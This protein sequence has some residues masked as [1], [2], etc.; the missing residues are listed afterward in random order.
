MIKN[1]TLELAESLMLKNADDLKKLTMQDLEKYWVDLVGT[2]A[3]KWS[4]KQ[5]AADRIL[6]EATNTFMSAGPG[7][8]P[9][10]FGTLTQVLPPAVIPMKVSKGTVSKT[11]GRP[12]ANKKV[13]TF[14]MEFAGDATDS[15]KRLPKQAK[16][17]LQNIKPGDYPEKELYIH[18]MALHANG[19]LT[20][21]QDPWRIFQY[22]R[23]SMIQ[24]NFLTMKNES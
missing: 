12:P 3:P 21:K 5:V 2:T 7:T 10:D 11:I 17:I 20:T 16:V 9:V 23:S 1:K 15:F 19:K 8:I 13:Y 6:K 24:G 14:L 22:Y 4:S 18:V